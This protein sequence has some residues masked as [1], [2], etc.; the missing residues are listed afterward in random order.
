MDNKIGLGS[1]GCGGSSSSMAPGGWRTAAIEEVANYS[2]VIAY[3]RAKNLPFAPFP[4][5]LRASFTDP[6]VTT[7]QA[8]SFEGSQERLDATSICDSVEYLITAPTLNQGNSLKY[9]ND[10]FFAKQSGIESNLLVQGAPRYSVAPFFTPLST[11]LSTVGQRWP[12]GWVLEYTQS[13][14]MQMIATIPLPALPVNVVV[15]FRFWQPYSDIE[16]AGMNNLDA[17][18]GLQ[19]MGFC[20][21][22]EY[23]NGVLCSP[24]PNGTVGAQPVVV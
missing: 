20:S 7:L 2:P 11:L 22:W 15:T 9:V 12:L 21:N 1:C 3:A 17:L 13:I 24:N 23:K 8:T 4:I 16:I 5:N 6:S 19:R 10:W 14:T 18:R